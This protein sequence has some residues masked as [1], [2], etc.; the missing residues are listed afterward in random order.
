MHDL[1]AMGEANA[2]AGRAR[3]FARRGTFRAAAA[4]YRDMFGGADGRIP[5]T[6]QVLYL[7]GWRPHDSQQQPARRG[8]GTVGL[9]E[10]LSP[11]ER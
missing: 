5:A 2:A 1:R 8:S 10:V 7:T 11:R 9:G 6:F 4:Y 3:H